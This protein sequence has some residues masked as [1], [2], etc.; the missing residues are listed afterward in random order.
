M[1][2]VFNQ[3]KKKEQRQ[4]LRN[5]MTKAEWAL[6]HL[7]KGKQRLG[8]KFRRQFSVGPFILDFYCP[9]AMSEQVF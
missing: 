3:W 7:L 9:E 8:Y 2:T 6:W 4:L 1:T 5:N